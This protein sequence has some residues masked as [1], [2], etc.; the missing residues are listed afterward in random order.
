MDLQQELDEERAR[1][2][3]LE[4]RQARRPTP[5]VASDI[6]QTQ[7]R[8]SC[9]SRSL[10]GQYSTLE[11]TPRTQAEGQRRCAE[12]QADVETARASFEAM[13]GTASQLTDEDHYLS[14]PHPVAAV[15]HSRQHPEQR[16]ERPARPV[17]PV[18]T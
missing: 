18:R 7:A 15:E 16:H 4:T 14:R 5:R 12:A 1:L 2:R 10:Q 17:R 6:R 3:A 9:W 13:R 8:I 11:A